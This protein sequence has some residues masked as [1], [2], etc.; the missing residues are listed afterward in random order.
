VREIKFRAWDTET[1]NM[2]GCS[3]SM[4]T[5]MCNYV[6][7]KRTFNGELL[8]DRYIIMQSTGLKDKNGKEIFEGDILS[9]GGNT[10]LWSTACGVVEFR[11]GKFVNAYNWKYGVEKEKYDD[12]HDVVIGGF[13][14]IGNIFDNPSL[15]KATHER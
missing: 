7:K 12:L 10:D 15:L 3:L 14:N 13:E 11:R 4:G 5:I 9:Y 6:G 1:N 8:S 2:I